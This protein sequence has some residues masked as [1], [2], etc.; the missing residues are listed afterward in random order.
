MN[1]AA[2]NR[3]HDI[4]S[5]R[6]AIG[7]MAAIFASVGCIALSLL[8]VVAPVIATV[9]LLAAGTLFALGAALICAAFVISP[10]IQGWVLRA[11]A[12]AVAAVCTGIIFAVVA[13]ALGVAGAAA[14]LIGGVP[15]AL[16]GLAVLWAG[17]SDSP[18]EFFEGI[19]E[20][21]VGC[22]ER[23]GSS[24]SGRL[25][26]PACRAL[27][28]VATAAGCALGLLIFALILY[29]SV[30]NPLHDVRHAVMASGALLFAC[31]CGA[32]FCIDLPSK[33]QTAP[34]PLPQPARP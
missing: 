28:S 30:D 19:A 22:L 15:V 3:R 7:G 1:V 11:T 2:R 10:R 12:V 21:T 29:R 8:G 6:L 9:L 5:G 17:F 24:C 25:F 27:Y 34:A 20:K 23:I 14:A 33:R 31:A 13:P 26:A 18:F 4:S 16:F 32:A